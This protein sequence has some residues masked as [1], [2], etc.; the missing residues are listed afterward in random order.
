MWSVERPGSKF[1]SVG[2]RITFLFQVRDRSSAT[3]LN[4]PCENRYKILGQQ[5]GPSHIAV[6]RARLAIVDDTAIDPSLTDEPAAQTI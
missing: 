5:A 1:D 6:P 3:L 4:S 2:L